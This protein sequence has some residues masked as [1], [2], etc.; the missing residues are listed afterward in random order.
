MRGLVYT[1]R[2]AGRAERAGGLALEGFE[3]VLFFLGKARRRGA[4]EFGEGGAGV[5]GCGCEV[6]AVREAEAEAERCEFGCGSEEFEGGLCQWSEWCGHVW[7][8]E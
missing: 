7:R 3:E 5:G 8:F 6:F 1:G 2:R 4:G